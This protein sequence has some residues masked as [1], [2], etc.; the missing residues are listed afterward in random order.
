MRI[1][2][3]QATVDL[4]VGGAAVDCRNRLLERPVVEH[5]AVDEGH[6]GRIDPDLHMLGKFGCQ[7]LRPF[8][9]D[10]EPL[11]HDVVHL[12]DARRRKRAGER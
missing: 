5:R 3:E 1:D 4:A 11:D 6:R 9:P 10:P 8:R 7:E 2:I 12:E